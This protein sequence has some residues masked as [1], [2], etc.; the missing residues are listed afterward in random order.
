MVHGELRA[1]ADAGEVLQG[2]YA[3]AV[4]DGAEDDVAA[5]VRRAVRELRLQQGAVAGASALRGLDAESLP[6]V[7]AGAEGELYE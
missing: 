7:Q 1:A 2:R 4:R 3:G 6:E 5:A